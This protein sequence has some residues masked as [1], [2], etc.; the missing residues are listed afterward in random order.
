MSAVV[1]TGA[2]AGASQYLIR[3]IKSEYLILYLSAAYFVALLPFTPG[4]ASPG[5]IA[6]ILSSMLPLLVVAT[7]QTF[8]LI[9]GGID[10]SVTSIIALASVAG[11]SVM[12]GDSGFM[13]QSV[14]AVPGGIGVMLL[15]GLVLGLV[16]GGAVVRFKMPPFI[17]TLTTMMFFSGLA[18]WITKSQNIFNLPRGFN[19]IG[20]G[21]LSTFATAL[22]VTGIAHVALSRSLFGRWLYAAGH[23]PKTALISGVPVGRVILLA[24]VTS[25]LCASVASILYTGRLETGSPVLGQRILLDVIGAT[26]IGGTSLYGGKGKVIWTVFGVLFLTLLDNSMNLLDLSY[27]T[28]MMAKGGVILLAAVIDTLRNRLSGSG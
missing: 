24:Y 26:V 8:V 9:T 12:T 10:L 7:G 17:V 4:L 1:A 11:A 27:F 20:S 15:A 16:N 25:G 3:L 13:G 23:N 19:A 22:A 2:K 21:G 18:V 5:N 14:L 6:N 28:I